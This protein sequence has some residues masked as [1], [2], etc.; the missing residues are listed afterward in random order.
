MN[1]L[2]AQFGL[3]SDKIMKWDYINPTQSHCAYE[4]PTQNITYSRAHCVRLAA[5]ALMATDACICI[6]VTPKETQH[7]YVFLLAFV[8]KSTR[9]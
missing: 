9:R 4:Y 8:I 1:R 5:T 7:Q 2:R 3:C 6:E